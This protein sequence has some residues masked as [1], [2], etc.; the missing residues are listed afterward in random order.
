MLVLSTSTQN[1][2]F[3]HRHT[4]SRFVDSG[5]SVPPL[6]DDASD[7]DGVKD[8]EWIISMNLLP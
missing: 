5:E 7:I 8:T 4:H 6:F 3:T 2:P 1:S